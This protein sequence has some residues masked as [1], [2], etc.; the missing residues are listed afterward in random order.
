[1]YLNGIM[2]VS[3]VLDFQTHRLP[4]DER[5]ALRALPAELRRHRVVP[6][7]ARARAAARISSR[8]SSEA[9]AFATGEYAERADEGRLRCPPRERAA[10][11]KKLARFTGLSPEYV[12]RT[13]LRIE[14]LRFT[15]E[16][17]RDRRRTVGR[18]DSRY[19]G[20]DRDA[21]GEAISV[22][23]AASEHPWS[24]HRH[25]QRL[26]AWRS[27]VR[28]RPAL[29]DSQSQGERGVALRGARE[30]LPRG[31][32][33]APQRD[34]DQPASQDLPR[35]RLLRPRPRRTSRPSTPSTAWRWTR[36]CGPTSRRA[37]TRP[38]T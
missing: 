8:R 7:A 20:I 11:V 30:P 22:D 21:A 29:R 27:Q 32:G 5:P 6:P 4:A 36:R 9:E 33:D 17:L 3:V 13:N 18:L 14:I 38:A 12:E 34:V 16:L 35:Q 23:P 31:G 37:S 28:E 10:V 26:R 25:L 1:M 24:L 15:R 2:L 19:T